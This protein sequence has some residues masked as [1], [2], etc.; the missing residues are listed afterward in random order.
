WVHTSFYTYPGG[1]QV[2][3]NGLVVS[4]AGGLVLIDTA[5]GEQRSAILL[6]LIE[7]RIGEPVI[8]AVVTHFH[9]DRLAGVD[10]L[11]ARG[12]PVYA[13]PLTRQ[14]AAQNGVPLADL[15]L[16]IK[17]RSSAPFHGLEIAWPGAGHSPDNLVVWLPDQRILFAGCLVRGAHTSSAGNLAHA[18]IAG[19]ASAIAR[20]QSAYP[21]ASVVI[22][23]HGAAGGLEL[24]QHTAEILQ[25]SPA[26]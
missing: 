2:P 16:D 4:V 5:W 15:V 22:P 25:G 21:D 24:L 6:D 14:L 13:Q 26:D 10:V 12:I 1:T 7:E 20:L 8:A 9:Y 23:G 17:P 11:E 19:W 18:D 3:S